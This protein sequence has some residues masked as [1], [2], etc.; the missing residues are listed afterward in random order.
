MPGPDPAAAALAAAAPASP[1]RRPLFRA[2]WIASTASNL[3]SLVQTVGASW[4][5]LSLGAS[6]TL[7]ALVQAATALPVMLLALFAG[8]LADSHDRRTLMLGAQVFMLLVSALLAWCAWRGWVSPWSLLLFTFLIGC[9]QAFNG[10][11]W[12][13]AVGDMVPRQELPAAVALNSMGFNVARSVGPALGGAIVA[14]AGAAVAFLFNAL[15]YVG[16]VLVLARWRPPPVV[17]VLPREPLVSAITAGI[18]YV[19]MSP[20]LLTVLLRGA[21]FGLAASAVL[22]LMPVL[23]KSGLGG[24]PLVYGTLLGAFGVGAVAG[25]LLGGRLRR[26]LSSEALVRL[27]GAAFALALLLAGWASTLALA[28]PALLVC[29]AGWVLVLST[30]NV[31][32]QLSAPRWVVARA[33]SIYQMATFGGMALG[34]W[35]WGAVAATQGS[36]TA[37]MIAGLAL[38]PG[39]VLVG[40]WLPL[41]STADLNLD[42]DEQWQVPSTTMPLEPRSGPVVISIEYR[43]AESDT[44]DFLRVMHERR[45]SRRRDGAR[46]WRLLRDL[47]DPE[48]W[49]ERYETPTWLDYLRLNHRITHD[50]ARLTAAIRALHQ[51][52]EPPR[53][54]RRLERQTSSVPSGPIRAASDPPEPAEPMGN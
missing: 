27:A 38:L 14:A 8:A 11:A 22:A 33:L 35:L 43:I 34:S 3:G 30:L 18:R 42:L 7:V 25:A 44:L 2:V 4:L 19:A 41:R 32:V 6:A 1:F 28:L 54:R 10:P 47:V 37:L 12:Q 21:L 16:I 20:A 23:A 52:S 26:R 45:R 40:L 13:A 31:S 15:S 49:T 50:D 9:G 17:H 39:A 36:G 51:G 48:L 46:R 53:V 5:M 29:G 24:G